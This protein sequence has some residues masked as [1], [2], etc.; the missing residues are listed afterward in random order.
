MKCCPNVLH[1]VASQRWSKCCSKILMVLIDFLGYCQYCCMLWPMFVWS[2]NTK[3][4]IIFQVTFDL[5]LHLKVKW[6]S[7][8]LQGLF[9]IN[10]TS[11]DQSLYEIHIVSHIWPFSL[12]FNIWPL[13]KL[14]G[15]IKVIGF[16]AGYI[17]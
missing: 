7:Q 10:G 9:L 6:R 4:Y 11:Y 13:M 5:G 12:P 14:K 3:S 1:H 2:T 8:I 16:S 17:S 15:Q